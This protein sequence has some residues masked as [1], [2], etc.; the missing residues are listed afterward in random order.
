MSL[1]GSSVAVVQLQGGQLQVQGVIQSAQSSVIQ[2]PQQQIVQVRSD[3]VDVDS[4]D[5][6]VRL[7]CPSAS[8]LKLFQ[9]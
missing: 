3:G 7:W 5:L 4:Q 1:G 2:S 8:L 6:C 9:C